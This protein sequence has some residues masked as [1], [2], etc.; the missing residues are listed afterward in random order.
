MNQPTRKTSPAGLRYPLS[1]LFDF[2]ICYP[3]GDVEY[4]LNTLIDSSLHDVKQDRHPAILS[5]LEIVL[6]QPTRKTSPAGLRY[7]LSKLF[8]FCICYPIGD[9]EYMLNTLIDSSLH[10]VKQDRHPA[11]LS[12]LEIVL[13]Q[14]TRKTSPAGL[15]YPL[16]KLFDFCICFP[17]GDVEYMLNTLIDSSLH[18]VKQ[19]RHPAILSILEIC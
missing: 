2:C 13:N 17:I 1:K 6:N 4:M 15:R 12:I 7:P 18:D 10:D 8:D 14:P 3:I 9:V 19:D 5:I 11:I 16:S